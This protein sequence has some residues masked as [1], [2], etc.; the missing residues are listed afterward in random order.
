MALRRS[1]NRNRS[2]KLLD[3]IVFNI[4]HDRNKNVTSNEHVYGNEIPTIIFVHENE[5]LYFEL[6][7][8]YSDFQ[9]YQY[10]SIKWGIYL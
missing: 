7:N 4:N 2:C 9:F 10:G 1:S 8:T 6:R 3:L 5:T